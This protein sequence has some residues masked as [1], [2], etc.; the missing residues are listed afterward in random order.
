M[1]IWPGQSGSFLNNIII[2]Y[3]EGPDT[4]I[5]TEMCASEWEGFKR[6]IKYN[7]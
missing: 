1:F 6:L 3:G 4:V 5:D 7:Y 2:Y